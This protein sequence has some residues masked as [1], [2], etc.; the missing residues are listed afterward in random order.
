VD[1]AVA[2]AVAAAAE[3]GSAFLLRDVLA[4]VRAWEQAR[5]GPDDR[6]EAMRQLRDRVQEDLGDLEDLGDR[7]GLA[8]GRV[9]GAGGEAPGPRER[10]GQPGGAATGPG[11]PGAGR[12]HRAF[13]LRGG[14]GEA[15]DDGMPDGGQAAALAAAGLA[16][17]LAGGGGGG[18]LA[19]LIGSAPGVF[20]A[21]TAAGELRAALVT[22]AGEVIDDPD[23]P[24]HQGLDRAIRAGMADERTGQAVREGTLGGADPGAYWDGVFAGLSPADYRGTVWRELAGEGSWAED[25]SGIA[26]FLAAGYLALRGWGLTIIGAGGAAEH[27]G[28][29][30]RAVT[31]VRGRD[32]WHA[33]AA[34]LPGGG[35]KRRA[36]DE[37]G[38]PRPRPDPPRAARRSWSRSAGSART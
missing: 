30:G 35:P 27:R 34:R 15:G 23:H 17:V 37:P 36:E 14:A 33:T 24:V 5:A 19:A 2:V 10:A 4:A 25:G 9:A 20:G 11:V 12:A 1:A 38:P 8:G 18:F 16:P 31:V 7:A 13:R 29:V 22:L 6:D 26:V 21:G 28:P 3:P 32:G